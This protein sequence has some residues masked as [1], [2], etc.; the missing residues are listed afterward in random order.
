MHLKADKTLGQADSRLIHDSWLQL[1]SHGD[2]TRYSEAKSRTFPEHE[3]PRE[4][5]LASSYTSA[6]PRREHSE[7]HVETTTHDDMLHALHPAR[8]RRSFW[9]AS[10]PTRTIP[11]I[12]LIEPSSAGST[13]PCFVGRKHRRQIHSLSSSR[14]IGSIGP[15]RC[16]R[17]LSPM[18]LV[19]FV[20]LVA[21]ATACR[22][23]ATDSLGNEARPSSLVPGR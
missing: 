13:S 14:V 10:R 22:L 12:C 1:G 5:N 15:E 19:R 8:R 3:A 6:H 20:A 17:L 18:Q 2:L 4:R 23:D 16:S 11:G 9:T 21:P 7:T